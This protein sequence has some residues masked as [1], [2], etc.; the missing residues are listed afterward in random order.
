[1]L[2]NW[3]QDEEV[4]ILLRIL[5]HDCN[6]GFHD[7]AL[8]LNSVNDQPINNMLGLAETLA[9]LL[10]P[11]GQEASISDRFVRFQFEQEDD[12]TSDLPDLVLERAKV[13][14]ANAQICKQNRIPSVASERLRGPFE[15]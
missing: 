6:I 2:W 3:W 4:V 8:R 7:R 12:L 13:A 11:V 5:E 9:A 10:K 1:M 14:A 15:A